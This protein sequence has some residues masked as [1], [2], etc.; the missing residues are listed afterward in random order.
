M[1]RVLLIVI[2][3][4]FLTQNV[5]ALTPIGP[6]TA[7]LEEGKCELSFNYLNTEM[8]ITFSGYG[9]SETVNTKIDSYL[10]KLDIGLGDGWQLFAALGIADMD[11]AEGFNDSSVHGGAGWKKTVAQCNDIDWGASFQIYWSRFSEK[12]PI[13]VGSPIDFELEFSYYEVQFAI[14]PTYKKDNLCLYGGPFLHYL[15]GSLDVSAF[16]V[17]LLSLDVEKDLS[18]GGFAG[19][20]VDLTENINLGVEA[21]FIE[22]AEAVMFRIG[23]RF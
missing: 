6:P 3:V 11:D 18:V 23:Y 12:S 5:L 19:L 2:G 10:P 4:L 1:K 8:D 14:G 22:D 7:T 20:I 9:G 17:E 16:D 13:V 21:Q 15:K